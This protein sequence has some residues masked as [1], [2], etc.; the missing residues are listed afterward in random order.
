M[1]PVRALYLDESGDHN[2]AAIDP[3]YPVFVLG[4]VLVD[5]QYAENRLE[6]EVAR[7]KLDVLGRT[8]ISLHTMD[9][10]R[11]RN[12]FESL[13]ESGFRERFYQSLNALMQR[14]Q[15]R[16]I[17]CAIRKYDLRKR[18][19]RLV[20]DPYTLSLHVLVERMCIVVSNEG[21][22]GIIIAESRGQPMDRE[23]EL[24]WEALCLEGTA[25]LKPQTIRERIVDLQIRDKREN[26]AGLQ[27]ADLVVSPIGRHVIGKPDRD[28]WRS[29]E[30][31]LVHGRD[32]NA[33]GYG[34]VVMP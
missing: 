18:P 31:K 3:Q 16:I 1:R 5:K 21:A 4:G 10:V 8:D 17:A 2:M 22:N 9:I 11:Q 24:A 26:L 23:L 32:G 15:Y 19:G 27:L 33:E 34:L 6:E 12:G 20:Q 13:V 28:D 30:P 25:R 29:I 7:F 14:L